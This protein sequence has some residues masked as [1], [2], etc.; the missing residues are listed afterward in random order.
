MHCFTK[1]WGPILLMLPFA[2]QA[3]LGPGHYGLKSGHIQ[4]AAQHPLHAFE[5]TSGAAKGKAACTASRCEI[6]I[7]APVK[8]FDSSNSNRDAHML[9]ITKGIQFPLVSFRADFATNGTPAELTGEA[10]FAGHK[11]A[12]TLTHLQWQGDA[13]HPKVTA[14]STFQLQD[15]GIEAPAL[16]G[17]PMSQDIALKME[18]EFEKQP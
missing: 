18:A 10:E 16:L 4:Y 15:F 14:D 7:A 9:E 6:L 17:V 5:A 11:H 13:T 8:S 3:A 1:T 2:A 12:L